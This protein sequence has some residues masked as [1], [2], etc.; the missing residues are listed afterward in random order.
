MTS[1]TARVRGIDVGPPRCTTFIFL[2]T[3]MEATQSPT[4]DSVTII[5][6][7]AIIDYLQMEKISWSGQLDE[8][9]FLSRLFDLNSFPSYDSR[10]DNAARDIW[11]HR[12]NNFDWDDAW[13]F[14]DDRLGLDRSDET[15]LRFL[16]E[17]LHPLV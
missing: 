9:A 17:M 4:A 2:E 7:R 15:F 16:C 5:T 14:T 6:R 11:Q 3:T 12:I 10:F 1:S 13:V 8:V